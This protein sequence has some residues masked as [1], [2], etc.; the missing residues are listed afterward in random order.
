MAL[1][2]DLLETLWVDYAAV[3]PQAVRIHQLLRERGETVR[4]DHIALRTFDLPG[5][6]IESLDR[7]FAAEGYEAAQSY[8]FPDQKL[9]AYHYEHRAGRARPL[10]FVSALLVDELSDR[11][12]EIVRGLVAQVEPGAAAHPLFAVSGR[13]WQLSSADY[14]ELH[15]ESEHGAWVAAFGFR[16]SRLGV[17]AGGLRGFDRLADVNRFLVE[18]G[19]RLD[20]DGAIMGGAAELI[21]VSSTVADEVDVAL[22][23]GSVRVPGGTCQLVRRHPAADGGLLGFLG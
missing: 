6:E 4:T 11:A 13:L 16:A 15:R 2:D 22:T 21:E 19:V 5:V 12:Q 20:R 3:T 7:A 17:D 18:N 8:S 9:I 1:V 23:D 14:Q 10:L